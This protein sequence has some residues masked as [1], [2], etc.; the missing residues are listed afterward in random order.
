M[1]SL[2]EDKASGPDLLYPWLLKMF[3]T[4]IALIL[5]DIFHTSMREGRLPKL[6]REANVCCI[7]KKGDKSNP[8]NYRPISL[9][10]VMRHFVDYGIPVDS[11]HGFRTRQ[12]TKTQ[13]LAT[14]H[15]MAY[16]LQCNNSL[17]LATL[18][19]AKAFDKVPQVFS[20][21]A[22][23]VGRNISNSWSKVLIRS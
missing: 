23:Y 13:L 11:Q 20:S 21:L 6:W 3:E 8:E 1:H 2:I 9:T 17:S 22:N 12:S 14:V 7:F 19:F 4:E 15:D 16:A 18:D 10:C 5:T